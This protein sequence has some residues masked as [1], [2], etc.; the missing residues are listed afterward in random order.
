MNDTIECPESSVAIRDRF[1]LIL[2]LIWLAFA[3]VL[4]IAP[5]Q[6]ADWWMEQIVVVT[7]LVILVTTHRWFAFSR[8][9][10]LL[11]FIFL[12]LHTVGAHY[13][14]SQVPYREWIESVTG[15]EAYSQTVGRNHFD[16]GVHFLYGL[17]LSRP[18]REAFYFSMRPRRDLWSHV[19]VVSFVMATSLLY[20]LLEW[21]AA[22]TWGGEAGIAFLG[23]QGDP[24]DAQKDMLLAS[25]GSLVAVSAMKLRIC[26]TGFDPARSWGEGQRRRDSLVGSGS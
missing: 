19:V 14:Y 23:T 25:L 9:S 16:R 5:K 22:V 26:L 10:Y 13:T 24:W 3:A 7:G 15:M 12:C 8:A 18:W 21:A 11:G 1:P 4:G 6:R 2:G 20:E 17:L